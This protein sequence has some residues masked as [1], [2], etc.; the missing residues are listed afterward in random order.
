MTRGLVVSAYALLLGCAQ[1]ELTVDFFRSE[2][3]TFSWSEQRAIEFIARSTLKEVRPLLPALPANI[4]L[5]VRPGRDVIEETGE[6]ASAMAPDAIMWT[7]NPHREGGVAAITHQRLRASLFHEFHHLVRWSAAEPHSI[8]DHALFEG[9]ATAFERDFAG[10][11]TPGPTIR[12]TCVNG[13]RKSGSCPKTHR[14]G[15]GSIH[16]PMA[17]GGSA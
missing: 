13:L 17:A 4:Q 16:I 14:H 8:I 10:V 3:Y 11:K 5:T 15:I 9:M 1:H 2:T 12:R 7:V 6:T